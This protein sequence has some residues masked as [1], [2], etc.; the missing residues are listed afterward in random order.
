MLLRPPYFYMFTYF[1]WV[2]VSLL[3]QQAPLSFHSFHLICSPDVPTWCIKSNLHFSTKKASRSGRVNSIVNE[4]LL[5]NPSKHVWCLFSSGIAQYNTLCI[6]CKNKKLKLKCCLWRVLGS[7]P[8]MLGINKNK[9]L[10]NKILSYLQY[11]NM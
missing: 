5:M 10:L 2:S 8:Y 1:T 3:Q 11:H 6:Y 4:R 9:V 7:Y